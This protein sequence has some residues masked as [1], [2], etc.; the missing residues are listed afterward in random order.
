MDYIA[1]AALVTA[2]ALVGLIYLLVM[3]FV[4]FTISFAIAEY[5]GFV[6]PAPNQEPNARWLRRQATK[7]RKEFQEEV[8][9]KRQLARYIGYNYAWLRKQQRHYERMGQKEYAGWAKS[10]AGQ[11]KWMAKDLTDGTLGKGRRAWK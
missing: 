7:R 4:V 5:L 6:S 11:Y 3:L 1:S 2:Q 9:T 10:A 8:I